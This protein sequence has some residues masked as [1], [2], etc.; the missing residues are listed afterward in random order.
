MPHDREVAGIRCMQVL[1]ALPDFLEQQL[2]RS[3]I[4]QIQDH[5]RGCDWCESFGGEYA[6]AI[7]AL[8]RELAAAPPPP[9]PMRQ[10]LLTRLRQ[11]TQATDDPTATP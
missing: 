4:R 8:R 10:R 9:E 3:R 1:E 6:S 7:A 5:L 2:P 11:A